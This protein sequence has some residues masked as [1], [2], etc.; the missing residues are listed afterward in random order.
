MS[1][2]ETCS[3]VK[4]LLITVSPRVLFSFKFFSNIISAQHA[5][6]MFD[7]FGIKSKGRMR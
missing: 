6:T 1:Q 2:M 4:F 5:N 7:M 3:H